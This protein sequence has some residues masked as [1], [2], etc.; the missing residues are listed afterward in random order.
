MKLVFYI[1]I[2]LIL[3]FC[4]GKK[5]D[6]PRLEVEKHDSIIAIDSKIML[7]S[8]A[9]LLAVNFIDDTTTISDIE[10]MRYFY[11]MKNVEQDS[12]SKMDY[13]KIKVI[14]DTSYA[15][16]NRGFVYRE[17]A[18]PTE[19]EK[20]APKPNISEPDYEKK[21]FPRYFK[22][23]DSL[24]QKY[25]KS[26]PVLIYNNSKSDLYFGMT[27]LLII[28]EALDIDNKWKPIEFTYQM[29]GCG[30]AASIVNYRVQPKHYLATAIIK[31]RGNFKTKV[32]VNFL[33][34]DKVIYSNEI[35][36]YINRSQFITKPVEDIVNSMYSPDNKWRKIELGW[37]LH[38]PIKY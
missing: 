33:K 29:P 30:I 37:M 32:R 1:S 7:R 17:I 20:S 12:E 28:Q 35:I 14:I 8:Q 24:K 18:G 15:F 6:L 27:P 21:L 10:E 16:S 31:Y 5:N 23:L 34:G 9:P 25:L 3:S 36:G 26:Y 4:S 2:L 19:E 38:K 22:Q 13:E 11:N